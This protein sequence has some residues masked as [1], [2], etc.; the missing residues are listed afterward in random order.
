MKI[1][2]STLLVILL[3][4]INLIAQNGEMDKAAAE[5]Y[6]SGNKSLKAGDFKG[7]LSSYDEA[8]K[9]SQDYRIYYQRG[10]TLKKMRKYDEAIGSFKK[11][12]EVNPKFDIAYNGLGSTYFITGE[13]QNAVDAFKKFAELTE[14]ASLKDKANEYVSRAYAKLGESAKADGKYDQAINYWKQSVS[15]HNFDA[16]Y[17]FLAEAYVETGKYAEAL[18]A[19]DKALNHRKKITKGGP[20]YYKGLAFK[21]LGENEK[22]KEAFEAGKKDKKYS[23]LCE[24]ELKNSNL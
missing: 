15:Y 12:V 16:A 3:F 24:Y 2:T 17:L 8:L 7:A 6:N 5:F 1:L 20:L 22:A 21:N 18:E 10:I 13:Y 4:S 23:K 19:A 9:T 11:S 14:K